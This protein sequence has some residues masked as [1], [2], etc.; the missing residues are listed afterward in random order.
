MDSSKELKIEKTAIILCG[1]KGTRLG[2]IG[3]KIPKTLV[4]VQGK[5]ILWYI[6]KSLFK[7]KFNKIILPLG[8]K[9]N[10]I[11]NF[12]RKKFNDNL[13]KII[14]VDTGLDTNIGKRISLVLPKVTSKNFLLLNGDAIFD[15]N[16]HKIFSS[17]INSKSNLT[18]LS[19]PITYSYGTIGMNKNKIID[20]RRNL[21]YEAL[22]VKDNPNYV[23]FNYTGMSIIS[24]DLVRKFNK[25]II[26]SKNFEKDFYTLSIR[27]KKVNLIRIK[28]FWHS[29]DNLKDIDTV[30]KKIKNNIK[31]FKLKKIK[32]NLIKK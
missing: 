31:Y 10:K 2:A 7:N 11:K 26:K 18:F 15:L 32:I 19:G 13:N 21:V 6:I 4:S 12:I 22:K 28:G 25:T 23:A 9:G 8:Y 17:H 24:T 27:S 30:N 5:E 20:F 16:L 14:F 29:I 1:G 3:K